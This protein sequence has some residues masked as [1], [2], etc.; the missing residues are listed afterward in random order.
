M[1][2]VACSSTR[3]FFCCARSMPTLKTGRNNWLNG[4][5]SDRPNQWYDLPQTRVGLCD[6]ERWFEVIKRKLAILYLHSSLVCVPCEKDR[7]GFPPG[8]LSFDV[9][10]SIDNSFIFRQFGSMASQRPE[11]SKKA[12][13]RIRPRLLSWIPLVQPGSR[14]GLL[15]SL[16]RS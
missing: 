12:A 7:H 11:R 4:I 9:G 5:N 1:N 6:C 8:I 2:A 13:T 10:Y 14:F 3:R 15:Q 16:Q